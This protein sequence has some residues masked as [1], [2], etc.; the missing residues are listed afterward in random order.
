MEKINYGK[1]NQNEVEPNVLSG[2]NFIITRPGGNDTCLINGIVRDPTERKRIND[3]IMK[4]FPNV[5]QVGFI[6]LG[7]VSSELMMAGGE[8]CGNAT[9]STAYLSLRGRS[10]ITR[11]R[12]S[13]VEGDLVAGITKEGDAFA[14]M[15][16]YP[17]PKKIT[18][19]D[20]DRFLVEMQGIVHCVD[21][22][23]SRIQ[24]LN[25]E[26]IKKMSMQE[27]KRLKLDQYPASGMM[28]VEKKGDQ[29][30][31]APVVYVKE[32]DTLFYETACGSGTTALGLVLAKK[33]GSSIIDKPV[34]QPSG[35]PIKVSVRND[36][37]SFT[38]AEI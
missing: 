27:I 2:Y 34:I 9:R 37:E 24:G 30:I 31:L 12:V 4:L 14:Q 15:P 32:I 25:P 10:G 38:Y 23:T 35:M 16:I 29:Y 5:E 21:F 17:D 18:Q 36:G 7:N 13:G 22:D 33:Q 19:I 26:E 3:R 20:K 1:L 28:Y 8:F 6:E 11:L